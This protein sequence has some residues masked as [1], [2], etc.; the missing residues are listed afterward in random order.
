MSQYYYNPFGS[1]DVNEVMQSELMRRKAARDEKHEIRTI[2]F[3]I[4]LAIIAYVVLQS[5]VSNVIIMFGLYDL[6]LSS[7]LFSYSFS[8]VGGTFLSVL[9]P[10]AVMAFVNKKRY[11]YPLIPK[12]RVKPSRAF[13]WICFGMGSCIIA[14][15]A[16]SYIVYFIEEL[17]GLELSQ[18][19]MLEPDSAFACV[20]LVV[21]LAVMPGICEELAMRCFSLQLLRKYG[22]GFGVLAVSIVFGL[23]HANIVQFIFAFL[24]GLVLGFITVKTDSIIP[25]IFVHMLNNG[26][27]AVQYISKY[28]MGESAS[29]D[30]TVIMY[31]FWFIAAIIGTV[32]LFSKKEFKTTV[33]EKPQ[34]VLTFG[35]RFA[36]FLFPW[37]IIPFLILIGLTVLSIFQ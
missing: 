25:S 12:N 18:G 7:A 19:E 37:M 17:T 29:E 35:Q 33:S 15:F 31:I 36:A 34:T 2:S 11:S 26:M 21:C 20:V 14:N 30:L 32:Y 9:V 4:G 22:K 6:Y 27:S 13:A 16:V 8:V 24:I 23:L 5:I 10:F 1:S 3:S 28:A